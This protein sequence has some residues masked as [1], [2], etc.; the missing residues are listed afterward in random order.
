MPQG[1]G[2]R[3]NRLYFLVTTPECPRVEVP[4]GSDHCSSSG[5]VHW[6]D[7]FGQSMYD[8]SCAL[9]YVKCLYASSG[10]F[11]TGLNPQT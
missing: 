11:S 10:C 2:R 9:I 5:E 4:D 8:V 6:C 3:Q 7:M 1:L